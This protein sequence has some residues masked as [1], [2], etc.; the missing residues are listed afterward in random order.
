[1]SKG[2]RQLSERRKTVYVSSLL[3]LTTVFLY[4][5]TV[6]YEFIVVDDHMYVYQNAT[7]L[8]GLTWEGIK[9]SF[10]TLR[11]SNW[12]PL[13]W[14]S[15]MLDVSIYGLF[16]G[17]H[18]LTNAAFH[19]A[20]MILL[21]LVL[22]NITRAF[23]PSALAAALFAWHPA[24]VE[25]VAWICERRDVLNMFFLTLTVW[26]YGRYTVQRTVG[27]YLLALTLFALGLMTKPMLVTLPCV[28]VLLDY[29]PLNQFTFSPP[30]PGASQTKTSW[31]K[32]AV[33]K[34]PFFILSFLSCAVTV[35]AQHRSGAIQ[36]LDRVSFS[37][38]A[39]NSVCG[40]GAYL[41]KAVWPV[42][43]SVF[44]PLPTTTPWGLFIVSVLA[45]VLVSW[46]VFRLR[47]TAPWLIV[48]WLWFLGTLVPVIGLVQV[49]NQFMADRYT[50]IPYIGLF[51]MLAWSVDFWF[52][53][54]PGL[55]SLL[56]A[57]SSVVVA[58]CVVLSGIQLTY[59]RDSITLFTHAI[60]ICG[61]N[62]FCERNLSYALSE[63]RRG[64][65]AIPHYYAL[66]KFTPNDVK[67]RYNLGLEL[68]SAGQ[69]AEAETQFSEALKYQPKS[70]KLH[71]N[72]GIAYSQQGK[73][74]LAAAEFEKA[75][76]L[77]PQFPWPCLNYAVV[78][79]EKGLAGAAIT[80]YTKALAL[81]P[82]WAEAMDKLAFL[83]A[84]CPDTQ[85][86]DPARAI[87]LATEAN[88]L[89]LRKS[90]DLLNTLAIAYAAAGDFTNA[91]ATAEFTQKQ[92]R[93]A[94]LQPLTGKLETEI[95]NYRS[96]KTAP[97]DWK[98]PPASVIIRH[99]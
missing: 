48:G 17:G 97:A 13:T 9:W 21:F 91:L 31:Q 33:E 96:G 7:V 15:H 4:W 99:Q 80:N 42:H 41:D 19:I 37:A 66:L 87:K 32:L 47:L 51:I 69:P 67:V 23:W 58:A 25:S 30:G 77:N 89:T 65:E 6:A 79:Q 64:K 29:W 45:L 78:L 57:A 88:D 11:A 18:H 50:Y 74:D 59:W 3:A 14:I 93:P 61:S 16:A 75:I 84:T 44:Y 43:L 82:D 53:K 68:I 34:I 90:P 98:T 60:A 40:Y 83:L 20:N 73:L 63:A 95:E 86:R 52:K 55:K 36:T 46:V 5:R 28:L 26:A 72:L 24:H 76:Q 92:T 70:D 56:I 49:G 8:K 2:T 81:Q 22:K 62:V 54:L 12:H 38:R 71:N 35:F 94:G 39:I 1:M 27:K 10:T 85:W